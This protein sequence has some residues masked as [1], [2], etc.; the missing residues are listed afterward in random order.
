METLV[1]SKCQKEL[2]FRCYGGPKSTFEMSVLPAVISLLICFPVFIFLILVRNL[3]VMTA[4]SIIVFA[5]F[6]A[7]NTCKNKIRSKKITHD[8]MPI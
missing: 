5:Q 1:N 6:G 4:N 8:S 3:C 2:N 7:R